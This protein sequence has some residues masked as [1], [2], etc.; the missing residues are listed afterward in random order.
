MGTELPHVEFPLEQS[1]ATMCTGDGMVE[2]EFK[3]S[4]LFGK[5]VLHERP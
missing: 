1:L 3:F 4:P 2:G 5:E